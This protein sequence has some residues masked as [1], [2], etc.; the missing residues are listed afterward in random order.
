MGVEIVMNMA[1]KISATLL[2]AAGAVALVAGSVGAQTASSCAKVS[3]ARPWLNTAYTPQCRARYVLDSL[4]S[5]EQKLDIVMG[6]GPGG[7]APGGGP[8]WLSERGLTST[9]GSD[10]PSGVAGNIAVTA[11][12][13]PLAMAASFDTDT[14]R[15]YG[16]LIG[17]E[18][19]A[20]GMNSITGPAM[21]MTRTWH[22]GR[23]TESLG[24]DPY[25][26]ASMVGPEIEGIQSQHVV[27][28]AKHY[29]VYT[30]EQGRSGDSP[31]RA[32]PAHNAVVDMRTMR[33]IYL[34]GFE[35][36]IRV[37]KA[38]RV[39]CAFS[40]VN[41]G[42]ACENATLLGI[43]KNE[44]GFDGSVVPDF[45]DAQRSIVAAVNAGL[46]SGIW[47]GSTAA[48]RGGGF[49]GLTTDNSFNGENL[50][51]A[52]TA[53]KVPAARID[54]IL[55]RQLVPSFRIGAFD[56]P[57]KR[58]TG[59]VS[60]PARRAQVA[61]IVTRTSVLLK[62]DKGV[63]PLAAATKSIVVIGTQAGGNA[64]VTELG[65]PHV[66]SA[67][68]TSVLDGVRKRA[69]GKV[70]VSYAQGTL[71]LDPLPL[72][73]TSMVRSASG[74]AGFKAEYF[75]NPQ[76]NFSAAPFQSRQEAAVNNST[77][78]PNFP[79]NRQWSAR[80]S[81]EFTP[82]ETGIQH[83]TLVGSGTAN[84]FIGN[85]LVGH[86][87]LVDFSDTVYA[88]VPMTAGKPVSVR[89]EWTPR[90]VLSENATEAFASSLGPL[91]RLG[92]AGPNHL[93]DE[94]V[95]AARKADVAVVVVGHK[96]GEG[97][98]RMSLALP[99]DQDALISAVAAA[100]PHTVVILQTGGAVTMP[101]LNK[102]AGVMEMWLSGDEAGSAAA[103]LL[104]GDDDPSGRLPVTFPRDE[105][106]GPG[107]QPSGYPGDRDATG[108]LAD[109]HFDEGLNIGYRY[110]DAHNQQPLFAF[111]YGLSY[112]K[113][114]MQARGAQ[115]TADGGASVQVTVRNVGARA[116]SEV[117]QVYVSFPSQSGE[118]PRQLKG[119][120]KVS[121]KPGESRALTIKLAPEAF[122]HWD[123]A[124]NRWVTDPGPYKI[125]VARSSR[126]I[127]YTGEIVQP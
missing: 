109:I 106:Q 79:A 55:M 84:L 2:I 14:A 104:F 58:V 120:Q 54:D 100:N 43:L 122:R 125:V 53:G 34:P 85:K 39:M 65:S 77:I 94:A 59:D 87:D 107:V 22:F 8:T 93:I 98:D 96:V 46:D 124:G 9:R 15:L 40:R 27:A 48:Q 61:D 80:W 12:P 29:A 86:F 92:F 5:L 76:M 75:A 49:G 21:D 68:L 110:W 91:L 90:S 19:F 102:V 51:E 119:F 72:L 36:A 16:T 13:A 57:G 70:R 114:Q 1:K 64:T 81:G 28:T 126:D 52:V 116:G 6:G 60:T 56:H 38:G 4:G 111:G 35:A 117:A 118:P 74:E 108:A 69:G 88:D 25:L 105:T 3:E 127:V 44:W 33:E 123:N 101:W 121:L 83:F 26:V 112:A 113:F 66:P 7:G 41:G 103:R 82:L 99:G 67:H 31:L 63:L 32:R 47:A 115:R 17:E 18:F 50:R 62:N 11:F 10:G 30:Q 89:V 71:G 23:S 97:M 42:Y 73:P 37:G 95:A 20:N 78:P 45:P 24:E